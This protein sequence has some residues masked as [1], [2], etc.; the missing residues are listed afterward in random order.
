MKH[1]LSN[2]QTLSQ[3]LSFMI[4]KSGYKNVYIAEKIG[5]AQSHFSVKKQKGN[6]NED[7]IEKI[8]NIIETEELEDYMIGQI[9][10]KMTQ[11]ETISFTKLK[12]QMGWK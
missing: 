5:M 7:E 10:H 3:Q 12:A 6:W 1:I 4:D 11:D 9:M 2:Y 8:L